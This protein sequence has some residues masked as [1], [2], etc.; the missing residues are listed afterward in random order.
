MM[1]FGLTFL[2]L[3]MVIFAFLFVALLLIFWIWAIVDCLVSRLRP[4]HKLVWLII[5]LFF[6]FIGALLYFI[7]AKSMEEKTTKKR[8]KGK[9]LLRSKTNRMIGGVC[10]GIGEYLGIDPTIVR[11][12]WILFTFFSFG[13]GVLAYIIAWIII[14][15][16]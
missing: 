16:K 1:F 14:P 11:L 4:S 13:A 6:H 15:E 3:W 5:V 2:P 8:L 10:G 7:F 9:R 12:L